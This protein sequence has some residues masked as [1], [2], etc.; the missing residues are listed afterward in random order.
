MK[1]LHCFQSLYHFFFSD[2]NGY[3]FAF[4]L[5]CN[6]IPHRLKRL[7]ILFSLRVSFS[8]FH[9]LL[10]LSDYCAIHITFP[11]LESRMGYFLIYVLLMGTQGSKFAGTLYFHTA[12]FCTS[13]FFQIQILE[14]CHYFLTVLKFKSYIF[15][16]H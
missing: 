16:I 8:F 9:F 11:D 5:F 15:Y 10:L 7:V 2:L 3:L 12:F 1:T 14:W 6:V 13:L 4:L